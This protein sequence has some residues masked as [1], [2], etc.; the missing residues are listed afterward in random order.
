MIFHYPAFVKLLYLEIKSTSLI[1]CSN[2]TT[3]INKEH[4]TL[5]IHRTINIVKNNK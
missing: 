5:K 1:S 4:K 2:V 3:E